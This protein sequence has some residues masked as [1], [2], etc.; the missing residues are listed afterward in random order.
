MA[1]RK[2]TR[3]QIWRTQKI[4]QERLAR[5]QKKAQISTES[6]QQGELGTEQEGLIV[7]RYGAAVD[8]ED[9]AQQIYRCILRQNLGSLV[10][11]DRVVW[12]QNQTRGGVVTALIPRKSVLARPDACHTMVPVA[13]NIDQLFIV[14]GITPGIDNYL[15]DRYLVAAELTDIKPCLIINKVDLLI[16]S[17]RHKL[18]K[19]LAHYERIGYPMIFTS[20]QKDG[21][22]DAL[23]QL[24]EHKTSVFVGVSGAGK[25]S[26]TQWLHPDL[27]I[28]TG[29]LSRTTGLGRH[30]TSTTQLYHLPNGGALIDSP[31]VREFELSNYSGTEVAAG[32]REFRELLGHCRFNNCAHM[33]E[34]GCALKE[35]V[36]AG[37]ISAE[38]VQNYLRIVASL[39]DKPRLRQ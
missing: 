16:A 17:A 19:K 21:G 31:G 25:S 38:R 8:V 32:F 39:T 15:I 2:L 36:E 26:I 1:K 33:A 20:T 35:Q 29:A 18:E 30:T 23:N 14:S 11:G 13:A 9:H 5:A 3:K 4:Q 24:L 12:Q 27:A 34:P 10:C 28:R 37:A 7:A 6:L 22:M